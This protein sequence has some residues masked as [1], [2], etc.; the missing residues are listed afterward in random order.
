MPASRDQPTRPASSPMRTPRGERAEQALAEAVLDLLDE[1]GFSAITVDKI[2]SRAKVGKPTIY[3]RWDNK[4]QLIAHVLGNVDPP[5]P[6]QPGDELRPALVAILA[7]LQHR[8]TDT[9]TGRVW[10]RLVGEADS[11]PEIVTLYD[12]QFLVPRRR[13]VAD[14]LRHHVQTGELRADLNSDAAVDVLLGSMLGAL[15]MPGRT[16]PAPSP[17]AI[18]DLLIEG[19][20]RPDPR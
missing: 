15:V 11:Y 9:R 13:A 5:E 12:Q 16:G 2:A 7:N 20:A 17:E 6:I 19:M 8:L 14:L 4:E 10:Q 3:R 18:V 1:E